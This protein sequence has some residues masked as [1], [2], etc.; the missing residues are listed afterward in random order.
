[1]NGW[2]I[3]LVAHQHV[4]D[5]RE[6]AAHSRRGRDVD[7]PP[8]PGRLV[9]IVRRVTRRLGSVPPWSTRRSSRDSARGTRA[10][11]E[12]SIASTGG[13]SMPSGCES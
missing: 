1:M 6:A 2:L 4:A 5:L 9:R 12:P 8:A 7:T 10:P 13:S 11:S 3:H